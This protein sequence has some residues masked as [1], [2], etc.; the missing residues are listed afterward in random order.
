[1]KRREFI[2]LLGGA[3]AAL[4]ARGTCAAVCNRVA[5]LHNPRHAGSKFAKRRANRSSA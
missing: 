2:T 4:A 3:A 5:Q 1:M